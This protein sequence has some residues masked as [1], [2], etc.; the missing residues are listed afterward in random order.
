VLIETLTALVKGRPADE[1]LVPP[2][3]DVARQNR[4]E[5]VREAWAKTEANAAVFAGRPN[6]AFRKGFVS[7][8]ARAGVDREVRQYLVGQSTGLSGIYTDPDS[9]PLREA[10]AKVPAFHAAAAA[11][12]ARAVSSTNEGTAAGPSANGSHTDPREE[13]QKKTGAAKRRPP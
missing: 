3:A 2:R 5:R 8:L 11:V 9:L 10:V 7:G 1:V 4:R 12:I 13:G 6:H